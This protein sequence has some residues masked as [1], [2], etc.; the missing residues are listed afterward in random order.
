MG[1][2]RGS[3]AY[4][5]H[6]NL[7]VGRVGMVT[8]HVVRCLVLLSQSDGGGLGISRGSGID[9]H[10]FGG[11]G[12]GGGVGGRSGRSGAVVWITKFEPGAL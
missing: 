3:C 12:G 4:C 2:P 6:W 8:L 1:F 11:G 9:I 10:I 7:W 5:Q